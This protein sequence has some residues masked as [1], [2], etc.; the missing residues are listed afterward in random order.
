[1][2]VV[3]DSA[4]AFPK[5]GERPYPPTAQNSWQMGELVGYNLFALL[6]DK[7]MEE[8][9][10][11]DSGTLASLGRKDAVATIGGNKTPLKGLPASLM[12]EASNIRYLSHIKGL[13]S[14]AY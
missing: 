14:L 7:A 13:F 8:F 11:I 5:G 4:V 10:P 9:N 6:K 1:V 12:K 2:F 3:G